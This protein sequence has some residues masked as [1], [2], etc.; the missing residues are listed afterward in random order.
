MYCKLFCWQ[1]LFVFSFTNNFIVRA[2][3]LAI[4][5]YYLAMM[6]KFSRYNL[7]DETIPGRPCQITVGKLHGNKF[8]P[9]FFV[10]SPMHAIQPVKH[11]I[12]VDNLMACTLLVPGGTLLS[13][14]WCVNNR[15]SVSWFV[16]SANCS[17]VPFTKFI[18][19]ANVIRFRI[20]ILFRSAF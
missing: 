2:K 16:E 8:R 12:T 13:K 7:F 9:S 18:K 3:L 15:P 10:G 11:V 5:I 1:L 17:I 14:S 6:L 4:I 19:G 20:A